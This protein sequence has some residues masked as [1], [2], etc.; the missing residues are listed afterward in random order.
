MLQKIKQL[1]R[2]KQYNFQIIA[3]YNNYIKVRYN[4]IET[5]MSYDDFHK[6]NKNE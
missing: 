6:L 5:V 3:R 1:K 4:G 2:T